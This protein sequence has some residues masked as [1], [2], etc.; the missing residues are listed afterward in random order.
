MR[1]PH[2]F[3]MVYDIMEVDEEGNEVYTKRNIVDKIELDLSDI[4]FVSEV[5]SSTGFKVKHHAMIQHKDAG[6]LIV[7][8]DYIA[9]KNLVNLDNSKIGYEYIQSKKPSGNSRA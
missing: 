5:R 4:T 8:G 7:K 3:Q 2:E 9:I 6:R 1:R